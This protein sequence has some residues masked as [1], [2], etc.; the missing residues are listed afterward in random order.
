MLQIVIVIHV[1]IKLGW[2]LRIF[3]HLE[4]TEVSADQMI[5]ASSTWICV[6]GP[7]S[8]DKDGIYQPAHQRRSL[9]ESLARFR[10][11]TESFPD[12]CS[13]E[14]LSLLSNPY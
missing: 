11:Q 7:L 3:T 6:F 2:H 8:T 5:R 10:P 14:N 4:A 13:R 12:N 9:T 1:I